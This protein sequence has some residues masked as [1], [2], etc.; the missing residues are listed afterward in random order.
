MS[1]T[2]LDLLVGITVNF[3]L[4]VKIMKFMLEPS[5]FGY[6]SVYISFAI[7]REMEL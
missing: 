6:F 5:Y 3:Y 1:Q 7:F 4:K 2:L